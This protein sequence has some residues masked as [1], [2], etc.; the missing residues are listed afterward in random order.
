MQTDLNEAPSQA[1]NDDGD[2]ILAEE[3]HT[4]LVE[5]TAVAKIEKL[6]KRIQQLEGKLRDLNVVTCKL[7]EYDAGLTPNCVRAVQC[8]CSLFSARRMCTLVW[9]LVHGAMYL[10]QY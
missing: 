10:Y 4:N 2:P 5:T 8:S 9:V 7:L 1:L 3:R 6:A